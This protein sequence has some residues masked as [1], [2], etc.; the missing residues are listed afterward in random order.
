M[1][2]RVEF[3][4][5]AT[6]SLRKNPD[7]NWIGGLVGARARLHGIGRTYLVPARIRTPDRPALRQSLY[8]LRCPGDVALIKRMF[9]SKI[10]RTGGL[11]REEVTWAGENRIM[12]NLVTFQHTTAIKS[13]KLWWA[14]HVSRMED[15]EF[16]SAN[17]KGRADFGRTRRRLWISRPLY[18]SLN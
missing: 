14:T 8:C 12:N 7:T 2:V 11:K 3:H 5:P 6:L 13:V 18:P 10:L 1:E 17:L 4:A 15:K 16:Q 9:R